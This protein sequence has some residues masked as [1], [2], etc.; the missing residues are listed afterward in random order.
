MSSKKKVS[1]N[2]KK[3]K[4]IKNTKKNPKKSRS[5]NISKV[6]QDRNS[7]ISTKTIQL[8]QYR[9]QQE[10]QSSRIYLS[11]AMWLANEG[12]KNASLLWK[13]YADE[14]NEHANWARS[15]LLSFGILPETSALQ[16]TTKTYKSFPEIVRQSYSH[17]TVITKQ[18]QELANHALQ[19]KDNMLY[20][21]SQKYLQE[22]IEEHDKIQNILDKLESFGTTKTAL[23]LIDSSLEV[24]SK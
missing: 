10:E 1:R 24:S 19:S 20:T 13:K 2:T 5:S 18:L 4:T 15:Y 21:L 9:I 14:E 16:K 12:Y 11:M 8:L 17:E 23:Q 3:T 6:I 22:Q 7:L